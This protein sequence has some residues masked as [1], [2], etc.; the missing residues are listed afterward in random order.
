MISFPSQPSISS[1]FSLSKGMTLSSAKAAFKSELG[2]PGIWK[3]F[4]F[5]SSSFGLV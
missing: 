1:C 3:T 4:I 5:A 2:T